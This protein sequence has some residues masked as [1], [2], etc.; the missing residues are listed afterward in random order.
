MYIFNASKFPRVRWF[1]DITV[2]SYEVQ[3]YSFWYQ[4][5]EE[6]HTY[7]LVA[8]IEVSGVTYGKSRKGVATTTLQRTC[9][10]KY[11][12][13]TRVILC[14]TNVPPCHTAREY[15]VSSLHKC[16]FFPNNWPKFTKSLFTILALI[17]C[18]NWTPKGLQT[19]VNGLLVML[20]TSVSVLL[21]LVVAP[22]V[23]VSVKL[24][25][26]GIK[27]ACEINPLDKLVLTMTC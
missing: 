18:G 12:W 25:V 17:V 7:T 11:L 3:W 1:Y 27:F 4:W 26:I 9:C 13:R 15:W 8:N 21:P 2:T 14:H 22:L 10:K 23:L 20:G 5:I 16:S 6:V 24:V 19:D